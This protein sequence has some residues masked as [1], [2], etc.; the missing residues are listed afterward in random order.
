MPTYEYTCI[1]CD[2]SQEIV[3]KFEDEEIIPPCPSCGYRMVRSYTAPG[4]QF[5]GSGFY[6]T[7]HGK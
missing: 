2:E 4:I 7:D 6:K 3:R 5:K 1:E